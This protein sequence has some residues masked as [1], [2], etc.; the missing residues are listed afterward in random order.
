MIVELDLGLSALPRFLSLMRLFKF[1]FIFKRWNLVD[2]NVS[3]CQVSF[4]RGQDPQYNNNFNSKTKSV[5]CY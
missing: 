2:T 5:G 1:I 3:M 4:P